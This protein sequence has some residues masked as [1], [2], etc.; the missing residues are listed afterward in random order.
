MKLTL[1][2]LV[3]A[4]ATTAFAWPKAD[5]TFTN[6]AGKSVSQTFDADGNAHKIGKFIFLF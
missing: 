5:F 3:S 6:A 1:V 4:L 2:T